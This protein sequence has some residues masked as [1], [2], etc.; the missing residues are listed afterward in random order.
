MQDPESDYD[1]I[2]W[3]KQNRKRFYKKFT[4]QIQAEQMVSLFESLV[5]KGKTTAKTE[6]V[7]SLGRVRGRI[8]KQE[9]LNKGLTVF[10]RL[11]SRAWNKARIEMM[12]NGVNDDTSKSETTFYIKE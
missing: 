8:T 6:S 9:I 10:G 2:Y 4:Y 5:R 7:E 3:G 1:L 11:G 12:L